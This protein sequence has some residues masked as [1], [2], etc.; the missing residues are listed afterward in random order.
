VKLRFRG[1]DITNPN[2]ALSKVV[3][4]DYHTVALFDPQKVG[5]LMIPVESET[6]DSKSLPSV[7]TLISTT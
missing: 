6:K 4:E 7:A 1:H 2:N 5:N 3:P